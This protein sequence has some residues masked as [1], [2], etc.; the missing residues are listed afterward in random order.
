MK[1][2]QSV[3]HLYFRDLQVLKEHQERL[4]TWWVIDYWNT[5][6]W[7]C[8]QADSRI[9]LLR[10]KYQPLSVKQQRLICSSGKSEHVW[11]TEFSNLRNNHFCN[12]VKSC[13]M[14]RCEKSQWIMCMNMRFPFSAEVYSAASLLLQTLDATFCRQTVIY[15]SFPLQGDEGEPGEKGSVC[16]PKQSIITTSQHFNWLNDSH[17]CFLI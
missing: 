17:I 15:I 4:E 8:F 14:I 9:Y 11:R 7:L 3:M 13:Q 2:Q 5:C 16:S 6:F 10:E 1:C 12:G